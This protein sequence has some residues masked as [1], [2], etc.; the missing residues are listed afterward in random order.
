MTKSRT[1]SG[2]TIEWDLETAFSGG[3]VH[4][5]T[6]TKKG[7][8]E[9]SMGRLHLIS[10]KNPD[11]R[12][13][14]QTA[15]GI[16][17]RVRHSHSAAP[18]AFGFRQV[19]CFKFAQN[20]YAG[21]KEADGSVFDGSTGINFTD[22]ID[23]SVNERFSAPWAPYYLPSSKVPAG[24]FSSVE[25]IDHPRSKQ[26]LRIRNKIKDRFNYIIYSTVD[27]DFLTVLYV[28]LPDGPGRFT[29]VPLDGVT[30]TY[31]HNVNVYWKDA[32]P[33]VDGNGKMSHTGMVDPSGFRG[34]KFLGIRQMQPD[35]AF[36]TRFNGA[37][38]VAREGTSNPNYA[39]TEYEGYSPEV[40]PILA[41][42][43]SDQWNWNTKEY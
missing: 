10:G 38:V 26:L 40:L 11:A 32:K 15:F 1:I 42:R 13:F 43:S 29:P 21:R 31:S 27:Y 22:H 4:H 5:F 35:K 33:S 23:C 37:M 8:Y 17:A 6:D 9:D 34:D 7:E 30:W 24:S 20:F 2:V 28:E 19:I 39:H 16:R 25:M 18:L 36:A 14:G 12:S 41:K 3:G